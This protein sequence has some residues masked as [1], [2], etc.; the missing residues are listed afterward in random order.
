MAREVWRCVHDGLS[1]FKL[2]PFH[3]NG[4]QGYQLMMDNGWVYFGGFE[5]LRLS[6]AAMGV[7]E[8]QYDYASSIEL[9]C[10]Q[11][12]PASRPHG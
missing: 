5:S 6:A 12:N 3:H 9:M 11:M 1:T 8:T 4:G 7:I 2:P 10:W